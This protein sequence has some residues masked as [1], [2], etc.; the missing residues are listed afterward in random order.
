MREMSENK[1]ENMEK[2]RTE[3]KKSYIKFL[4]ILIAAGVIGGFA[5]FFLASGESFLRERG[6][7]FTQAWA[8]IQT[9]LVMPF[10]F[11]TMISGAVFWTFSAVFYKKAR[12]LW[13]NSPDQDEEYDVVEDQL[14]TSHAFANYLLWH[15][16]LQDSG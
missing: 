10:R 3:D 15:L 5:G 8:D 11:I 14:N 6:F 7:S 13:D 4:I 9:A 2:I 1:Q 16:H 12:K